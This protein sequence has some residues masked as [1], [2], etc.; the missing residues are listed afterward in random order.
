VKYVVI[1]FMG[2]KIYWM[3]INPHEILTSRLIQE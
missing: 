3:L 2:D 1:H